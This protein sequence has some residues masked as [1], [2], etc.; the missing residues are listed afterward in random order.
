MMSSATC[1]AETLSDFDKEETWHFPLKGG[2]SPFYEPL[3]PALTTQ[4]CPKHPAPSHR[5]CLPCPIVMS[6]IPDVL[7][8]CSSSCHRHLKLSTLFPRSPSQR[9]LEAP[10]GTFRSPSS[11][12]PSWHFLLCHLARAITTS[13][14]ISSPPEMVSSLPILNT[15]VYTWQLPSKH[16]QTR[17]FPE[18]HAH[19]FHCLFIST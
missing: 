2:V 6:P 15:S 12:Q 17:P 16:F 14:C 19:P 4:L 18:I 13:P 10:P 7:H 5:S 9:T 3:Y 11:I 8:T 1:H